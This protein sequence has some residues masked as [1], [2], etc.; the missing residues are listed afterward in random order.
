[1]WVA[2]TVMKGTL[3]SKGRFAMYTI[4]RATSSG[5]IVGSIA[6]VVAAIFLHEEEVEAE[7]RLLTTWKRRASTNMW[8]AHDSMPNEAYYSARRGRS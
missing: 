5:L 6:A 2:I 1:M 8:R 3:A 4:A 7:T